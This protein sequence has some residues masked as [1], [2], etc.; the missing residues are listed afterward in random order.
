MSNKSL[1]SMLSNVHKHIL[2]MKPTF[3]SDLS[4]RMRKGAEDVIETIDVRYSHDGIIAM[5]KDR[6]DGQEYVFELKP[7]R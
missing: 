2:G 6:R 1:S 3:C 5:I 7:L 4:Y